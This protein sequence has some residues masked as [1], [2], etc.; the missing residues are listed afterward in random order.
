MTLSNSSRGTASEGTSGAI[1]RAGVVGL[2]MVGGSVA[3]ALRAQGWHVTGA[4]LDGERVVEA[5]QRNII[6]AGGVD[7]MAIFTVIATPVSQIAAC[8]HAALERG[9]IV[10]DVGSVKGQV[11]A[12]VDHPRFVGGHPMA[13]SERS[14]LDGVDPG[15]FTG[16]TWVLT[17]GTRTDPHA[18]L[19]VR[20]VVT[21]LGAEVVTVDAVQHDELVATVSHVPHMV[22]SSMMNVAARHSQS[23]DVVLRLAAG[24]FRDMTRIAAGHAGLWADIALQNQTAILDGLRDVRAE[25][26]RLS[27]VLATADRGG[28]EKLLDEA[29]VARRE[30]PRRKG[31]PTDLAVLR[32][33]VPDRPGGLAEVFAAFMAQG[34]NVEDMELTHDTKGDR[35]TLAITVASR[36]ATAM[37]DALVSTGINV[38]LEAVGVEAL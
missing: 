38:G 10:T 28:L 34:V 23:S 9:G 25:L 8:A 30:L 24:G 35:G 22:A 1:R 3:A 14:G 21:E 26:D 18:Y 33:W 2:G 37:R 11:V 16:A 36:D 20:D 6:D 32:V 15:L 29:A 13:G 7:P 12:A 5:Q 27:E 4:D 17:P 19:T 31:R